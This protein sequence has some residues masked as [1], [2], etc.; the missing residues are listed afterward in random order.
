MIDVS[1]SV[2]GGGEDLG[3]LEEWLRAEPELRG[4]IRRGDSEEPAGSMGGT[5]DL[6]VTLAM[7]GTLTVIARSVQVWLIQR[8]SDLSVDIVSPDGRKMSITARRVKEPQGF[9]REV[10]ESL[11]STPEDSEVTTDRR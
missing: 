8:K 4:R 11:G 1:L 7:S 3:S 10:L 6:I 2:D 5:T 9:A